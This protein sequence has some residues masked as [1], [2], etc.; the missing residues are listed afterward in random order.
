MKTIAVRVVNIYKTNS[1]TRQ[2]RSRLGQLRREE[3]RIWMMN[4]RE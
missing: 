3:R 1:T 4:V 2:I